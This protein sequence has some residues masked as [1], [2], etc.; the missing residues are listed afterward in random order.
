MRRKKTPS[1]GLRVDPDFY[2]IVNEIISKKKFKD[3]NIKPI[4][5]SRITLGMT[6]HKFFPLIVSDL[7]EAEL[8]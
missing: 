3:T 8:K 7:I 4:K 6:R 5:S 1:R 2:K